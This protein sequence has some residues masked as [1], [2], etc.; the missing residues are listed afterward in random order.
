MEVP[1]LNLHFAT[2]VINSS[3]K[4]MYIRHR[5]SHFDIVL[6]FSRTAS[7]GKVVLALYDAFYNIAVS[8]YFE[9]AM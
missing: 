7:C 2:L 9:C 1:H 6:L 5:S 4:S 3:Q 8:K